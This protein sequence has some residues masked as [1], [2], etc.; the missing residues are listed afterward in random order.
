[1]RGRWASYVAVGDSFTEGVDDP[2][3]DGTYRGWAD[4]VAGRLAEDVDGFRYANLA[5]RGRLLRPV[6]DAQVPLAIAMKPDLVTF[7]AGA[8]DA[9][10]RRFDSMQMADAFEGAVARLHAAELD[11]VLFTPADLTIHYRAA[12][13]YLMPRVEFWLELIQRVAK[14]Y[15]ARLVDLW[16]DN[17]FRDRRLW[18]VDRL[19]L[20]PA[21]HRRVAYR[22]LETLGLEAD[23]AW[24]RPLPATSPD[25]W[26]TARRS[27]LQW[28]RAHLAPW[29]GRR[30]TGRSS[31]DTVTAKRPDLAEL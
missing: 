22:V 2:Y 16:S 29:I 31:G 5:V 30:L 4:L 20:N 21:G 11:V 3:G 18:S 7:V 19:H 24:M 13:R 14:D 1:V 9:I 10:R 15:D 26:V 17:G 6:V 23:E 28:A 27:D 8:N 25:G 12:Q